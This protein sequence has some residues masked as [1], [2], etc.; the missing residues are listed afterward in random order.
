VKRTGDMDQ[1]VKHL[2]S[3]YEV[4]SSNPNTNNNNKKRNLTV[5]VM[6]LGAGRVFRRNLGNRGSTLIKGLM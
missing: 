1:V 3:N 2:H 6:V 5:N 4:L